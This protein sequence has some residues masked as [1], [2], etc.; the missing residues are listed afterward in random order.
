M[1]RYGLDFETAVTGED[2]LRIFVRDME[3]ILKID[4]VND[5]SHYTGNVIRTNLFP[6]TDSVY[7]ILTN[8][9]AAISRLSPKDI[10]DIVYIALH[11]NF[12]WKDMVKEAAEKYI[13][14]N[15]VEIAKIFDEF[16]LEKLDEI[17]WI[18]SPPDKR[19][20]GE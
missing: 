17:I 19:Y 13:W 3:T 16:P 11:F 15:P 20:F 10:V 12:I 6:R 18:D 5:I 8:K 2:F 7:N 1:N 4:F 14:V 9:I